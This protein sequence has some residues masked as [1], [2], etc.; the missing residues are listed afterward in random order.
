MDKEVIMKKVLCKE[1]IFLYVLL[2]SFV[3]N[4]GIDKVWRQ[5]CRRTLSLHMVEVWG[6]TVPWT[7]TGALRYFGNLWVQ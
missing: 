6:G 3:L 1:I 5:C 2:S 4:F 7:D